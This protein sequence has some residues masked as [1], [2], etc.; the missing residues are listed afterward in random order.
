MNKITLKI[1]FF[2]FLVFLVVGFVLLTTVNGRTWTCLR[3][4]QI[5]YLLMTLGVLFLG[6][7]CDAARVLILA[8]GIGNKITWANAWQVV[9][10]NYFLGV[11]T[12]ASSG[13]LV[14]QMYFLKKAGLSAGKATAIVLVRTILSLVFILT[15][16]LLVITYD[17]SSLSIFLNSSRFF[18]VFSILLFSFIFYLLFHPKLFKKIIIF[19]LSRPFLETYLRKKNWLIRLE[20]ILNDLIEAMNYYTGKSQKS[21]YLAFCYT[22]LSWFFLF[23]SVP[24]IIAGFNFFPS[25]LK[26]LGRIA[27][28]HFLLYFAPTPGGTGIAEGGL[29]FLL[30][31]LV[32]LNILGIV[33][34]LWRFL[35]EYLPFLIGL[36]ICLPLLFMRNTNELSSKEI[37]KK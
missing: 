2:F 18:L 24:L 23:L 37:E 11:L 22:A 6:W 27:F 15:F 29:I 7:L 1:F 21:I 10:G 13:G 14:A 35:A 8:Q 36:I 20:S 33:A 9:F 4:I 26:V 19:F 32:P 12:P 3:A 16:F 28:L 25:F 31:D 30:K 34:V 5:Q 17:S